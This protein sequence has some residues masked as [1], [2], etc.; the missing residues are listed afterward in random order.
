MN[1]GLK[2]GRA[3]GVASNRSILGMKNGLKV[4][5]QDSMRMFWAALFPGDVPESAR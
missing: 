5:F 3:A 4:F 2:P 1:R